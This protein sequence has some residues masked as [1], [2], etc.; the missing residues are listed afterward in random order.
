MIGSEGYADN[1]ELLNSY[2]DAFCAA[3]PGSTAQLVED[4]IT[5]VFFSLLLI[6]AQSY[7]IVQYAG[8]TYFCLDAGHGNCQGY[9]C[10]IYILV[11]TDGEHRNIPLAMGIYPE[12]TIDGYSHFLQAVMGHMAGIYV[13]G[14]GALI[15]INSSVICTDRCRSFS[16]AI[17]AVIPLAHHIYDVRHIQENIKEKALLNKGH[18]S[19]I[20]TCHRATSKEEFDIAMGEWKLLNAPAA[21]YAN[22]IPHL[23]WTTYPVVAEA[24]PYMIFSFTGSQAV[25]QEM[26]RFK[27]LK[28]RHALPLKSVQR[29]VNLFAELVDG[30]IANAA[31]LRNNTGKKLTDFA[32][33]AFGQALSASYYKAKE[34]VGPRLYGPVKTYEICHVEDGPVRTVQW[35]VSLDEAKSCN[36]Q[37]AKLTGLPHDVLL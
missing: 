24:V 29:Y 32:T 3:N 36:C 31:A 16:P 21:E 14:M 20:W 8:R 12:E 26:A 5:H 35:P 17:T 37:E 28:I 27:R 15:N 22:K 18:T 6:S 25:E 9:R 30:G 33:L 7:R 34:L 11:G 19:N 4:P 10:K 13:G 23:F 1:F 2:L